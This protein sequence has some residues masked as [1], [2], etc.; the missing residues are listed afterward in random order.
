[1][2]SN[3][4]DLAECK[5]CGAGV[6]LPFQSPQGFVVYYCNNCRCRFSGYSFEPTFDGIQVFSPFAEYTEPF[7]GR[8]NPPLPESEL[9]DKYRILLDSNP[10]L[11]G[12]WEDQASSSLPEEL[13]GFT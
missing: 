9:L 3:M 10:P 4:A 6:L 13:E 11:E 8:S 1:M 7:A 2:G 12:G 5:A